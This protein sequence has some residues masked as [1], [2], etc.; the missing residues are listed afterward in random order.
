V[1]DDQPVVVLGVAVA[2]G[3]AREITADVAADLEEDLQRL[4]P[5]VRWRT[6]LAV[7]RLVEPPAPVTEL[8]DAARRAVLEHDWDL[9]V[10]VTD[11]PL[12]FGGRPVKRHVSPTH[13]VAVVSLPA[14]GAVHLRSRLRRTLHELV[15]ELLGE[16]GAQQE[17]L[18]ELGSETHAGVLFV[19]AVVLGHARLL[20]GMVRANRPW[21]LAARLYTALAAAIAAGAYGIVTDDIWRISTALGWARLAATTAVAVVLTA[22]VLIAAHDLWE[23]APDRRVRDQVVLFNVATATTIVLG[24]LTLYMA[25]FVLILATAALVLRPEVLEL[26]LV[27]PVGFADY[28][29]LTWFT[30][31][32]A[33]V[34]GALA[35]GLESR[36]AVREAAYAVVS[37]EEGAEDPRT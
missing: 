17:R 18:R 32:L 8:F 25:L 19:P 23:R 13:G 22:V 7:D 1:S 5:S 34:G 20:L 14:L 9:G 30:T 36:E 21:R 11:L 31:S 3:L 4:Y 35:A 37:S 6:E 24:F 33:T 15:G 26:A 10:V 28:L 2:P 27:R 12:R 16:A 29:A